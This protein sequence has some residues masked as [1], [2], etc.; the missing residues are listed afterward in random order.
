VLMRGPLAT[1]RRAGR[2]PVP[3]STA[4]PDQ[5]SLADKPRSGALTVTVETII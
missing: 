4:H 1:P 2:G 5:R 3:T